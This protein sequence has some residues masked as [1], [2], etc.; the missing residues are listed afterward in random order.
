MHVTGARKTNDKRFVFILP[1][2]ATTPIKTETQTVIIQFS[3][4]IKSR[5]YKHF[6]Y[7]HVNEFC[8]PE[9]KFRNI[10]IAFCRQE[11]FSIE[12]QIKKRCSA[13]IQIHFD[14]THQ[15]WTNERTNKKNRQTLLF[16]HTFQCAVFLI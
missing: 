14:D 10:L 16:S 8:M 12:A 5:L 13:N 11:I 6:I 9:H 2:K 3:S 7:L 4:V 1:K 15:C